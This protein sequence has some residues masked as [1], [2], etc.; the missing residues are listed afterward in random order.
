M[1]EPIRLARTLRLRPGMRLAQVML[2]CGGTLVAIGAGQRSGLAAPHP[3]LGPYPSGDDV[4]LQV[5]P[6]FT[7]TDHTSLQCFTCH[8][9]RDQHGELLVATIDG[10]RSCHH[11]ASTAAPCARCHEPTETPVDMFSVVRPVSFSVGAGDSARSLAFPHARHT[12]LECVR[13]HTDGPELAV[14]PA[15]DCAGCHA[16]HHTTVSDCASCHA[17]APVSAHPA[18]EA[19][20]TC[21][22]ASCHQRLPFEEVPRTREL[23]LGCHQTQRMHEAPRVCVECHVLPRPRPQ[24]GGAQ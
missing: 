24:P 5:P 19:H 21:S 16:E 14:S 6:G 1:P 8:E 22:G 3:P 18:A 23:C 11:A 4:Q 12:D 7:H 9:T 13:C 15:L 10:C 17:S 20:V 2:V